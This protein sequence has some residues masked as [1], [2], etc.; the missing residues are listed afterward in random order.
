MERIEDV[1]N[2]VELIY[3]HAYDKHVLRKGEFV[4]RTKGQFEEIAAD[5]I[6]HGVLRNDPRNGGKE[7]W[8]NGVV[9]VINMSMPEQS[10]MFTQTRE[11]FEHE[12]K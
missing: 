10:T 11:W 5:V 6:E 2:Y 8:H 12:L 3:G 7:Y 1:A 9:V 4:A